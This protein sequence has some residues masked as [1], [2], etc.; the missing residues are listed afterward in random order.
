[1]GE[2]EQGSEEAMTEHFADFIIWLRKEN[3]AKPLAES[4]QKRFIKYNLESKANN[5]QCFHLK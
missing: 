5:H 1:M 4:T 2:R 3:P